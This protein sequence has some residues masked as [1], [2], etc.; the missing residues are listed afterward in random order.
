MNEHSTK[1]HDMKKI[2]VFSATIGAMMLGYA[3]APLLSEAVGWR[4]VG[5]CALPNGSTSCPVG[6][7]LNVSDSIQTKGS[8]AGRTGSLTLTGGLTISGGRCNVNSFVLCTRDSDCTAASAGTTCTGYPDL[9]VNG[10]IDWNG[11]IKNGWGD[12][13]QSDNFVPLHTTDSGSNSGFMAVKSSPGTLAAISTIAAAPTSTIMTYGAYGIDSSAADISYGVKARA[14]ARTPLNTAVYGLAPNNAHSAWAAY[15]RGN[16]SVANG[17]DLT[18][19]GGGAVGTLSESELCIAEV[20]HN[21][22]AAPGVGDSQWVESG[23]YLQA[24]NPLW[25]IAVGG[26]DETAPFVIS[27]VPSQLSTD[28]HVKG[29]GQSDTLTVQ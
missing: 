7:S 26:H 11:Q 23:A 27:P 10:P 21:T 8:I 24:A 6:A 16:V 20:C 1:T 13:T 25:N 14:R 9:V 29:G 5:Q 28:L 4:D 2:T 12:I 3:F 17:Y 15:F 18:I 22:W 19:G